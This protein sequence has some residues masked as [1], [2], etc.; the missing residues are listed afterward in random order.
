MKATK[1]LSLV[2]A[3]LLCVSLVACGGNKGNGGKTS[4]EPDDSTEEFDLEAYEAQS[5]ALYQAELGEFYEAYMAAKAEKNVS[6]R[7]ALMAIA[8]AKLMESATM[9]PTQTRGGNYA[10]TRIAPYTIDYAL[11]GNDS[12]RFHN[13][14]VVSGDPLAK[15]DIAHLRAMYDELKG[16][17]T[18]W[19]GAKAYLEGQGRSFTDVYN[20][21]YTSDPQTWDALATSRAADSEAIVNTYDGL[22][23]YDNEGRL[24]PK[25]AESWDISEDGTKY[26]FKIREGAKW[27]TSQGQYLGEVTAEDFVTGFNHL[28]DADGGL[29]WLVDGVIKGVH[30]YLNGSDKD[31]SV[32]GVY[33]DAEANTVTY[34]LEDECPYFLTMLSYNI[35]APVNKAYF[36]SKGGAFGKDYDPSATGYTYGQSPFDIAYCGAYLVTAYTKESAIVFQAWEDYYDYANTVIKTINWKFNDATDVLKAYNDMKT[37]TL[38]GAGLNDYA[39]TQA[40]ADK[41]EGDLSWFDAYAYVSNTDATSFMAFFNINREQYDNIN[42]G[43]V[44]SPMNA[45]A[46]AN[47]NLAMKNVHFRRAIMFA[48][49]RASYN[50]QSVGDDLKYNS[51]R[52]SYTPGNFVSLAEEVTVAINGEDRTYAAGTNYGEIMQDQIDADGVKM[53]VWTNENVFGAYSSDGFDG[54]YNAANAQE[55]MAIAIEELAAEGLDLTATKIQLDLP[56]FTGNAS[57]YNR[58]MAFKKSIEAALGKYVTVNLTGCASSAQWYWAGY[59]TDFGYEANYSIYDVSGWGPDYGDPSTYL[60][61]FLPDFAGYMVKCIGIF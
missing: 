26:T 21:S 44:L 23:E 9:L 60:D 50:A 6:K 30:E 46:K 38:T 8:E 22:V 56:T 3:V 36:L 29:D 25:L 24:Q 18:Y 47:S 2:I 42:D 4:S 54:W 58:G 32:V 14:L 20:Y 59:Y 52:N 31:F 37:E 16:T 19:A 41:V 39:V 7:Y 11:W 33:A 5:Q 35:F 43:A 55:E 28:L 17:G 15:E 34:E 10:I 13:A 48:V 1:L 57:Y 40:K 61:T 53:I 12:N 51:L 45:A 27:V 49:D